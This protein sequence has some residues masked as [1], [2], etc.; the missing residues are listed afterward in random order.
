MKDRRFKAT[1]AAIMAFAVVSTATIPYIASDVTVSAITTEEADKSTL[2]YNNVDSLNEAISNTSGSDV[3]LIVE[4]SSKFKFDGSTKIKQPNNGVTVYIVDENNVLKN[5]SDYFESYTAA[6]TKINRYDDL[7]AAVTAANA[8]ECNITT[9]TDLEE[10]IKGGRTNIVLDATNAGDG[11]AVTDSSDSNKNASSLVAQEDTT[12][13][14]TNFG[15]NAITLTSLAGAEY[16]VNGTITAS[17][18]VTGRVTVDTSNQVLTLKISKGENLETVINELVAGSS[19]I[20]NGG[21]TTE[22]VSLSETK[23]FTGTSGKTSFITT[24]SAN[25][26]EISEADG[27]FTVEPK[28]TGSFTVVYSTYDDN[29]LTNKTV[30]YNVSAAGISDVTTLKSFVENKLT[31]GKLTKDVKIGDDANYGAEEGDTSSAY[32]TDENTVAKIDLGTYKLYSANGAYVDKDTSSKYIVG[33]VLTIP[34]DTNISDLVDEINT[35]EATGSP[36]SLAI[37]EVY[38]ISKYTTRF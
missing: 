18:A 19:G 34:K 27:V 38:N 21:E 3:A 9:T 33:G 29:K 30:T 6:T 28:N 5:T 13:K 2:S 8:R 7:A 24:A 15:T 23:I 14:F 10:Y 1:L 11:L 4:L 25:E 36:I 32:V 17:D 26:L 16:K 31:E 35:T 12:I 37:G 22:T 20:V